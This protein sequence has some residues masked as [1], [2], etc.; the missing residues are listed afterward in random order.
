[1]KKG[2][3]L[4]D[5]FEE[6]YT[7]VQVPAGNKKGYKIEYLYSG[8]WYI[9]DLPEKR[10]KKEKWTE[11]GLS[12][13]GLLLYLLTGAQQAAVNSGK[14]GVILA[15]LALCIHVLEISALI[16]F[17][18]AGYKTTKMT[19]QEVDRILGAATG[20]R[21]ILLCGVAAMALVYG[22][23]GGMNVTALMV[24]AGYMGCGAIAFYIYHRYNKIIFY[25]EENDSLKDKKVLE[26]TK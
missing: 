20:L 16:K 2:K 3:S 5:L 6:N 22:V 4:K 24:L 9:W 19:Y 17:I 10:L 13:T 11:L 15:A 25:T 7:A 1:M 14:L 26:K 23:A 8:P 12:L 21:G 18:C